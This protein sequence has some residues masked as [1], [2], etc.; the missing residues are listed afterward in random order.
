VPRLTPFERARRQ[1]ARAAQQEHLRLTIPMDR[2]VE[3]FEIIGQAGIWL[4]FQPMRDLFGASLRHGDGAGIVINA[5]HPLTLQRF[6]AAHEYGHHSLG[7][8]H[9]VDRGSQVEGP[10][11]SLNPAEVASQAFASEF[12]M[13]LQLCNFM[14]RRL[15]HSIRPRELSPEDVYRLSLEL[16]VSFTACINQL[17][18]LKKLPTATARSMRKVRPIAIKEALTGTRPHDSRADVWL[19]DESQSGREFPV[20]IKDEIHVLL[21]EIPSSGYTWHLDNLVRTQPVELVRE[22][23]EPSADGQERFGAMGR[24][25]F[26]LRVTEPGSHA[27]RLTRGRPWQSAE[28]SRGMFEARLRIA[29]MPTG[30]TDRGLIQE[31]KRLLLAAV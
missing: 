22:S 25:H 11:R 20:R 1:G 5:N 10:A 30:D 7:H 9:S 3:I 24:H 14:L 16:G 15:V 19:M 27:L 2:R 28:A 6:T 4:M 13:P 29:R 8:K 12:L 21:P 18:A 23:F 31:Q 26:V 17:V